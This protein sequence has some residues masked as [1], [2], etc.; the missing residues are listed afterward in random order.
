LSYLSVDYVR[1]PLV[2][3]FFRSHERVTYL[4]NHKL[5]DLFR[6]V[7]FEAGPWVSPFKTG[8]IT[9]VPLR[10]TAEQERHFLQQRL[11]TVKTILKKKVKPGCMYTSN[12]S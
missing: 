5:Q 11:A 6:A 3:E 9:Q 10:R 12:E 1:I 2:L 8:E 4:F 7:L